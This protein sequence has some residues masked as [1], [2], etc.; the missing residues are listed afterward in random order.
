M[1]QVM[2]KTVERTALAQIRK[3]VESL[4]ENS[5]LASAFDG[6]FQL[7]E[8]NIEDDAV[9]TTQYYIDKTHELQ[10]AARENAGMVD[11]MKSDNDARIEHL[12]QQ[13]AT[14]QNERSKFVEAVEDAKR[15]KD[16]VTTQ[17]LAAETEAENLRREVTVLK[18]KLYDLL[19]AGK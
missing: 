10:Q 12:N 3:I 2:S 7:A 6:A 8:S 5:Y 9:F 18:A 4:G 13:I 19:V 17:M 14:Y 15:E 11:R 16:T 1:K